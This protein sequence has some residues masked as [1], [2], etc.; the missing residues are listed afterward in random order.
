MIPMTKEELEELA[1]LEKEE[2]DRRDGDALAAKRQHLEALRLAKRLSAKNGVPGRDFVVLETTLG[3]IAVRRPNEVE[4]DT[5][6]SEAE[7][8]RAQNEQLAA[9]VVLEPAATDVQRFMAQNPGLAGAI[10]RHSVDLVKVLREEEG[11]K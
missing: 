5:Y 11:K 1:T 8:H 6:D 9:S 10:V 3:N 4:L 7:D 2:K